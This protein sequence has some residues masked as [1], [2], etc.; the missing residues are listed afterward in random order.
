MN[1]IIHLT[2][3]LLLGLCTNTFSQENYFQDLCVN[4]FE[5]DPNGYDVFDNDIPFQMG[6]TPTQ[7]TFDQCYYIQDNKLFLQPSESCCDSFLVQYR[8]TDSADKYFIN[9]V[10]KCDDPPTPKPNC[11]DIYLTPPIE[12]PSNPNDNSKEIYNGCDSSLISYYVDEAPGQTIIWDAGPVPI[13]QT[14]NH[15]AEIV[16][17]GPGD[18]SLTVTV[19]TESS[20]YCIEILESPSADFEI[21][22]DCG[23]KNTPIS[24][25]STGIGGNEFYWDFGDGMFGAGE[26]VTHEYSTAGLYNV[27]LIVVQDNF[28][29]DMN[30]LC[31]C[32]DTIIMPLEIL[33]L[34]G[35]EIFWISTL[36]EG[37]STKYWSDA[38]GCMYNWTAVDADGNNVLPPGTVTTNDTLCVTWND[39][40]FGEVSLTV[41]GCT[42]GPLCPKPTTAIIPIIEDNTTLEGPDTVCFSS[43]EFYT[44]PKWPTVTYDWSISPVTAGTITSGNGTNSISVN[45]GT[46][47]T[48]ATITVNYSS[49]FLGGIAGHVQDDCDGTTTIDVQILPEFVL[50]GPQENKFC[51]DELIT[52][53][54]GPENP[55]TTY[56]LNFVWEVEPPTGPITTTTLPGTSTYITSFSDP[57]IYEIKIY[58]TLP[59]PYCNDTIYKQI[60]IVEVPKMDSIEGPKEVCQGDTATYFGITSVPNT[61]FYWDAPGGT[62]LGS[63]FGNPVTVVWN[64]SGP[65]TITAYQQQLSAPMCPSDTISCPIERKTL[66]TGYA[67]NGPSACVNEVMSYSISPTPTDPDIQYEWEIVGATSGSIVAGETGPNVDVQWNNNVGSVFLECTMTLC[68][69][70]LVLSE[71]LTLSEAAPVTITQNMSYCVGAIGVNLTASTT[72]AMSYNWSTPSPPPVVTNAQSVNVTAPGNYV[73]TVTETNGCT[74]VANYEVFESGLPNV[75]LTS[76]DILNMCIQDAGNTVE[77]HALVGSYSYTWYKSTNGGTYT[78]DP[79]TSPILSYTNTG[80]VGYCS[81]YYVATDLTTMCSDQ[82][83]TILVIQEDCDGNGS[84]CGEPEPYTSNVTSNPVGVNCNVINFVTSNSINTTINGWDFNDP[85]LINSYTGPITSP[86]YTFTEAGYYVVYMYLEVPNIDGTAI[87][88]EKDT[89]AV[90]I[91]LAADFDFTYDCGEYTFT[92]TSTHVSGAAPNMWSWDFGDTNFGSGATATHTYSVGVPTSFTVTLTI[93]NPDDCVATISKSIVVLPPPTADII[94]MPM[95]TCVNKSFAFSNA[96]NSGIVSWDWQFGDMSSNGSADPL[97]SYTTDNTYMVTLTVT[98]E[99]GCTNS[100]IKSVVVHPVVDTGPITWLDDLFLC[101]GETLVLNAPSGDLYSWSTG[102]KTPSITVNMSDTYGVTVTDINGCTFVPDSVDVVVYPDIDATISGSTVICDEGCTTLYAMSGAGYNYLWEGN[103]GAL[104]ANPGGT[105][106]TICYDPVS[107]ITDIALTITDANMCSVTSAVMLTYYDSPDVVITPSDPVLCAGTLNTLTASTTYPDPVVYTWST[108]QSGPSIDVILEGTY[109]VTVTDPATGCSQDTFIN[110][111]PLPDLCIIP[112]GCY[113]ACDPDTLCA[114]AGLTSY[115]W[116]YNGAIQPMFSGLECIIVSESGAYNF[117]GTNEFNCEAFSDTLYLE[118]IPCCR[119]GDTDFSAASPAELEDC[120]FAF[121]YS[122]NQDIF[123]SLD[124]RSND[125]DLGLDIGSVDPSLSVLSSLPILNSFE[126]STAGDPLPL[127][128]L[129]NFA[130][131]CLENTTANPVEV[132]A[133]WRGEDGEILC[134]DT[135]YLECLVEPDCI[136]VQNDTLYC[137]D[138]DNLIYELTICNPVGAAYSISYIDFL[139]LTPAGVMLD[140]SFI[141]LGMSPLLP[142]DCISLTLNVLGSGLANQTLCYDLVGHENNPNEDPG[143][144][145]CSSDSTYCAFIP[146]CTRCD[147]VYVSNIDTSELGEC[148]YDV[149]L[150]N[151]F[152]GVD[153]TSV[154]ICVLSPNATFD[155]YNTV[156][157]PW[158]ITS[159]SSTTAT[160]DYNDGTTTYIPLGDSELPTICIGD[161]DTPYVDIEIKWMTVSGISCRDTISLLCP[162]DCGYMSETSLE[163]GPNGTWVFTASITNT[164]MY[165]MDNAFIDFG[166]DLLDAYDTNIDLNGLQPGETYGPISIVLSGTTGVG[167]ELCIVTTLH[168][169][170][171]GDEHEEC[172][173]FKTIVEVPECDLAVDCLCN[174]FF[175]EQVALGLNCDQIPGTNT[176]VFSPIGNLGECDKVVWQWIDEQIASMTIGNASIQH[177][178]PGPGEYSMCMIVV[179]TQPDG[180]QCKEKFCKDVV[181]NLD[182]LVNV[183]PNPVTERINITLEQTDFDGMATVELMDPNNRK[184]KSMQLELNDQSMT[185]I[186]VEELKTGIYILRIKMGDKIHTKRILI[187]K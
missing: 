48:T 78:L 13:N 91:P 138:N 185:S 71:P 67:I 22:G 141:N 4:L 142:G 126:S 90:C 171:D 123:Y 8:Y 110:V 117:E 168:A 40:P 179:R 94:A 9:L 35:P 120:C 103:F 150:N 14:S 1:K 163:C 144:L 125:A 26:N 130:V 61:Q 137:D 186:D 43:S 98:D 159:L 55:S 92:S 178:F 59:N 187:V 154:A 51:I 20:T 25:M 101:P 121:N 119:P 169:T 68:D 184:C 75:N 111:N 12:D 7:E 131:I 87:C 105:S 133:D 10:I 84:P 96:N 134:S 73:V 57:G 109:F 76:P 173:Q 174:P 36:C 63:T 132:I 5:I 42:N 6:Q 156:G 69:D 175:E 85:S 116:Y 100:D 89:N 143:T 102:E 114:P 139:E 65:Y 58:P 122:V 80:I 151:Y 53:I 45:W 165:T 118:L 30:P 93:S 149:T 136:Y 162:G 86:T 172:C 62:I 79:E 108:G 155:I 135:I 18:Y 19:G 104:T 29:D 27:T 145:C 41:S 170:N 11:T 39:G 99:N 77:L 74:A 60:E 46:T 166:Q 54:A 164:S 49:E 34:E 95:D 50:F 38:I 115:E 56:P 24:F 52:F 23:C 148:C 128:P 129:L 88:T 31:C 32:S 83:N 183:F 124:I 140:P 47:A 113:T 64:S 180:Q 72:G 176:F 181:I 157:S 127:G 106:V 107:T 28:D 147:M 44:V 21:I 167:P 112:F 158:D 160:L 15:T 17:P 152:S 33:D 97:H 3:V 177:T 70:V 82:S 2:A 153:L 161:N 37:D 66:G 16:W 182:G 81:Y 146:G